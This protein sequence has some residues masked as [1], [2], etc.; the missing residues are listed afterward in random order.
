MINKTLLNI[1]LVCLFG[2]IAIELLIGF[3]LRIKDKKDYANIILVNIITNPLLVS[4]ST[5]LL[6]RYGLTIRNISVIIME[7]MVVI[8]EGFIYKKYLKYDKLNPFFVS[9]ILNASSYFIGGV[10]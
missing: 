10:I 8:V 6:Y 4:I 3:I 7:I 9:L 5:L 2:T 1:M